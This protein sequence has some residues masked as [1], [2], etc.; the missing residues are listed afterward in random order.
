MIRIE[1]IDE[2]SPHLGAVMRLWRTNSDWLGF[3]PDGAFLDRARRREI[4]VALKGDV[5]CGYLLYYKTEKRKVRLTH[6]CI[7]EGHRGEGLAKRLVEALRNQTGDYLGIGLYCRRDFPTWFAWPKLGFVALD[8][9]RGRGEDVGDLTYYWMSNLRANL[10]GSLR[11]SEDDRVDVVLDA[12]VFFDLDD[13]TRNEAEES[14]GIIAD[15]L[16]PLVRLCIT[17]ELFNEIH[18]QEDRTRR[19]ERLRAARAF[20]A[21]EC[22][23]E[24]F[25]AIESEV[26]AII[27]QPR[28]A[29]DDA[30]IRQVA[31]AIASRAAI[32]VTRDEELLGRADELYSKYGLSV[33][34]PAEL[35]GRFEELR[36]EPAYQHER[37]AGTRIVK[38][39]IGRPS[40]GLASTFQDPRGDEKQRHLDQKFNTYI[41]APDRFNCF[42]VA[43]ASRS[44]GEP[45]PLAF[46]VTEKVSDQVLKIPLFRLSVSVRRTRAASTLFR[47]LLAGIVEHACRSH[48]SAVIFEEAN[49]DSAWSEALRDSGFLRSGQAWMKLSLNLAAPPDRI[50]KA[51]LSTLA[52][53]KLSCEDLAGIA[54]MLSGKA[55]L[56]DPMAA[57]EAEHLLWP[58][59][60]LGCGIPNYVV[61]IR[62]CWAADLFDSGLADGRLW[63][64][65]ADLALNPESVYYRSARNSPFRTVG[66]LLW[67]VSQSKEQGS[68]HIRACSRLD[69]ASIGR[70]KDMFREFRR[71]GVY[72]WGDVLGTAK[73]D[74]EGRIM[75]LKFRGTER[76]SH[77]L[78]WDGFQEILHRNRIQS[79]L[80]SPIE[81]PEAVL[82]EI[83]RRGFGTRQS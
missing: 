79:N 64:A 61:P 27:G 5:F 1:P 15:W 45:T 29:R 7:D 36:N 53:A 55:A 8:E 6:L 83:Y 30:D 54:G 66:R 11:P 50:A 38:S 56:E 67:Y 65:D 57:W 39:R 63:G 17:D 26:R 73:G 70:A 41:S 13:P 43:D 24:D 68:M 32:F 9:K 49:V 21:L 75:A 23:T 34:R 19:T 35:V 42:L 71:L 60:I 4:L 52:E 25:Q 69:G 3:Y 81:I 28:N 76:F 62:P 59:K 40:E 12:N 72:A 2:K 80:Q 10:L 51:I 33:V 16:R 48:T 22:A 31:R 77:P 82:A 20:E 78:K 18:R 47:T 58:A 37:I 74:P 44:S 46:Y 14:Q